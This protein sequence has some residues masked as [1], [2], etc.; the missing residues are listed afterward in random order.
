MYVCICNAIREAELRA[1]AH[2]TSGDAEEA[3][4]ALGKV[5]NCGHCLCDADGILFEERELTCKKVA[6]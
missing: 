6:A 5:P 3:Y 2:R 4:A 1:V